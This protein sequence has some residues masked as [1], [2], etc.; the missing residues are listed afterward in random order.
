M[1]LKKAEM[2]PELMKQLN[3][4]FPELTPE[5]EKELN[6]PDYR[7][8]NI[9]ENVIKIFKKEKISYEKQT[10]KAEKKKRTFF[11]KIFG[12]RKKVKGPD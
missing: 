9:F 8:K 2:D 6:C 12:N 1:T 5:L 11:N 4:P 3:R 7:E 10:N